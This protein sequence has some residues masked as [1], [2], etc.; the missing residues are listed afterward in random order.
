MSLYNYMKECYQVMH[1]SNQC[2]R[3]MLAAA[4]IHENKFFAISGRVQSYPIL[5]RRYKKIHI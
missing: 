2:R 1:G 4:N 5:I 3:V